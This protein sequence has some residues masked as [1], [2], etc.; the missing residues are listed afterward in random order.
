VRALQIHEWGGDLHEVDLREP[1]LG[2]GEVR[3]R[4]LSCGVGLTV[5]NAINGDLA[6]D[7]R[8][9]LPRVPGHEICGEVLEVAQGVISPRVGD[10]GVVYFYLTCGA[11]RYC[12][13]G[14]EP[15]CERMRG[16]VGVDIDG[17]YAE[18]VVVPARSFVPVPGG[19]DPVEATTIPDAIAT[20]V[21][22]CRSRAKVE[23]GEVV[24]VVGA[25][26][27]VGA[28]LV[29]VARVFGADVIAIDLSE[30]KLAFARAAGAAAALLAGSSPAD[31]VAAA[32]R[33]ADVV[34][35]TVGSEETLAWSL[36]AL[37]RGGRLV[38]LTTFPGLRVSESTARAVF[39]EIAIVGSRY[40]SY[41]DVAIAT[42]LVASG[43]VR[44]LVGERT[45]LADA[46]AL[47]DRL[48]SHSLLGR[49]ALVPEA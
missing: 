2:P 29:Q 17:G 15:L 37:G 34:V 49:G 9:T 18:R 1:E 31:V 46:G 16:F 10:R 45:S 20:P 41:A 47:H 28:H 25:G 48:R 3:L 22:V 19:I 26:G 24:A 21:H 43:R 36:A 11:C 38:V 40:A 6:G 30:E 7:G 23:P 12:L 27:G 14:R 33:P 5:L 8:A 35:D 13:L 39:D 42:E 32:G 44:A 4:I